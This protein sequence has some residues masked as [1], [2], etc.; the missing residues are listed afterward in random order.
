MCNIVQEPTLH[1]PI[2]KNSNNES[3]ISHGKVEFINYSARYRP[4]TKLVLEDINFEIQPGEKVGIVGRTGAGKSSILMA[5]CRMIETWSGKILIDGVDISN[6][7]I[8][9]LWEQIAVIPQDPALLENTLRFN[10]DPHSKSTDKEI[11]NLLIKAGCENLVLN[12]LEG[13]DTPIHSKCSNFSSGE[14]QLICILRS[15][16]TVS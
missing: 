2:P 8:M 16:L 10:L 12:S 4:D 11:M 5:L 6:V 3:W 13:L 14:K 9:D 1:L 15:I 7:G